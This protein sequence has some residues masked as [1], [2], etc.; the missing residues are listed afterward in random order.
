[1]AIFRTLI[2]ALL[3]IGGSNLTFGQVSHA[4]EH[5][6]RCAGIFDLMSQ[7]NL[8]DADRQDHLNKIIHLFDEIYVQE[9]PNTA[10]QHPAIHTSMSP[11]IRQEIPTRA[12]EL[13]EEGILCGAWAES[14]LSQG[15]HYK[16][17]TVFPK[18]IALSV[19]QT[20]Q[21]LSQQVFTHAEH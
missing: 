15:E 11:I 19:R 5:A 14:M 10:Q 9:S 3:L 2:V 6:Q 17:I 16:F 18:V 7:A 12:N 21:P 13:T 20:Y 8:S 4:S 1:M